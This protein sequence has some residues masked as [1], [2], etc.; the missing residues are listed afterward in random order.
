MVFADVAPAT[1]AKS[2]IE[3]IDYRGF[4]S[5][6]LSTIIDIEAILAI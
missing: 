4:S 2:I 5:L 1:S 3:N 6:A